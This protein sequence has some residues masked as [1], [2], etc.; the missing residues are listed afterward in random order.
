[1]VS[2]DQRTATL[3]MARG[4]LCHETWE[5]LSLVLSDTGHGH[6]NQ[7]RRTLLA[8]YFNPGCDLRFPRTGPFL[9][10]LNFNDYGGMTDGRANVAARQDLAAHLAAG[11]TIAEVA[12]VR[13]LTRMMA[14]RWNLAFHRAPGRSCN[15]LPAAGHLNSSLAAEALHV[16]GQWARV[17]RSWVASAVALVIAAPQGATAG[18]LARGTVS[19]TALS[20]ARMSSAFS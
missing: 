2:A 17:A 4:A 1:M 19:V 12:S 3:T 5:V 9:I 15:L 11:R 6:R 13:T 7:A 14:F 10:I 8:N 16:D 20:I 18:L